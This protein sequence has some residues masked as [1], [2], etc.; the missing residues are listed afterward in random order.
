[1]DFLVKDLIKPNHYPNFDNFTFHSDLVNIF[2]NSGT[3]FDTI[4]YGP[5]GAGKMTLFMG[6]LQQLFGVSVL[7][8]VPNSENKNIDLSF[9]LE[10]VG[11]PL[12]NTNL[13]VINDSVND[14]TLYD[15]LTNEFDILGDNLN[16]IMI[17]HLERFKSKTISCLTNFIENR[18]SKTYILATSNHYDKLT[19]RTKSRFESFKVSR[20]SLN[21]LTD[22]FEQLI[23]SKFQFPKDKINKIIESTNRCMKLSI[24]YLNQR[25]LESIDSSLKK[26][27]IDNFKY[28]IGCLLQM[29]LK[30]DIKNLQAIRTMILTLY[31]SS[32]TW[33]EFIDKTLDL[34]FNSIPTNIKGF[35]ITDQ[36]KIKIIERTAELDHKVSLT[37]PTYIHYEAFIF[38]IY[39]ILF[40]EN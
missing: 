22:Y 3:L 38:T 36:Q 30:N 20:P 16:Y 9:N 15:F 32:L 5:S 4:L 18:Q 6:Y 14:E 40:G 21:E 17:L 23:P 10:R 33:N 1:M 31:Q 34:L 7:N 2:K 35:T 37:K 12:S 11:V 27:S 13:V 28:Y 24:I 8:L 25:L 26:K 39:E 29:I 19:H